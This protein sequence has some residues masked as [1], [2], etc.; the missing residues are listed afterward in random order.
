MLWVLLYRAVALII[1]DALPSILT[2]FRE[3]NCTTTRRTI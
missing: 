3:G 2:T 1:S